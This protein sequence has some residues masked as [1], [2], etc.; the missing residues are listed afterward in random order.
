MWE[1]IY[2]PIHKEII[3]ILKTKIHLIE[4]YDIETAEGFKQYLRH[5]ASQE[6]YWQLLA[7]GH[8]IPGDTYSYPESFNNDIK[9][10][11]ST[12]SKRYQ[13]GFQELRGNRS[14]ARG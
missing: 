9:K 12:V 3:N 11:L 4:G 2:L 14:T 5:Y 8:A 7:K 13:D 1:D 10:G 6:I